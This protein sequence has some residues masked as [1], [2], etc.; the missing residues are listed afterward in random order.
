MQ[1]L[2]LGKAD[3]PVGLIVDGLAFL[4]RVVATGQDEPYSFNENIST[5]RKKRPQD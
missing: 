5:L 3:G 2:L 4:A 1:D